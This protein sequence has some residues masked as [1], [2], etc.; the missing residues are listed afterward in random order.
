MNKLKQRQSGFSLIELMIVVAI[1]LVITVMAMP[2]I[3]RAI[4]N[5]RLRGALGSTAGLLQKARIEAVRTNRVQVARFSNNF[6]GA[7]VIYV[8]QAIAL[9]GPAATKPMVQMPLGVAPEFTVPPPTAFPSNTLLGYASPTPT[10]TSFD[11]YFSQRGLPC[12]YTAASGLCQPT[13]YQY[14]FRL[15]SSFGDQWGAITIT[16]AGRI[17]VWTFNGS[18]WI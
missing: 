10:P 9:G 7:S 14:Y 11:V 16:P 15:A 5:I 3:S 17:R 18:N 4:T 12:L 13:A 6:S 2:S 8:D 1:I